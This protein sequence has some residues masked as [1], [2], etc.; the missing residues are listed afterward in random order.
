MYKL[1]V[2]IILSSCL[3][4]IEN[5]SAKSANDNFSVAVSNTGKINALKK[6]AAT[7][8]AN[9][10][11]EQAI[12]WYRM[13]IDSMQVK[14]TPL[15]INLAHALY[16]QGE[17]EQALIR[18]EQALTNTKDPRLRSIAYNQLGVL[19]YSEDASK[20][21]LLRLLDLFK[22][23]LRQDPYNQTARFNYERIKRLLKDKPDDPEEEKEDQ[24]QDQEKD[25]E[26]GE[27]ENQEEGE[28]SDQGDQG[29]KGDQGEEG[30][31]EKEAGEK[32]DQGEEGEEEKEAGEKGNQK[33]QG[34]GEKGEEGEQ[35]EAGRTRTSNKQA[36]KENPQVNQAKKEM[37]KPK[38]I[39]E[40]ASY[41]TSYRR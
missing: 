25:E 24:D 11:Y 17:I 30:E 4:G 37:S 31:D 18:Y 41:Q 21:T 7:A 16:K 13:L 20:R 35:G 26:E 8:L 10:R 12:K 39:N 14:E 1:I 36:K 27:E 38:R 6:K 15:Y 29:E 9:Q 28:K 23:A 2:Y 34:E 40:L 32:G 22:Q 5:L 33:R 3:W 19:A